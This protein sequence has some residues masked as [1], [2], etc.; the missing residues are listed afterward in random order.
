MDAVYHRYSLTGLFTRYRSCMR[1]K[2]SSAGS[3]QLPREATAFAE[4][5]SYIEEMRETDRSIIKLSSAVHL[6]RSCLAQLGRD[7]SQ[8]INPTHLKEKLLAQ[9]PDLEAHKSNYE[10]VLSLKTDIGDTLL[11]AIKKDH[12]SDAAVLM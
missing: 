7:T 9:I 3:N 4:L 8:Q 6:Y 2:Q 12:D 1:Q 5:I 10:V 11:E